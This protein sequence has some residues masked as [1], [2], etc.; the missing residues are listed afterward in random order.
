MLALRHREIEVC[1]VTSQSL[2]LSKDEMRYLLDPSDILGS[3]CG[4]ESFGALKRAEEKA[5]DGHFRTRDL[6]LSTWDRMPA[7]Q[8]GQPELVKSA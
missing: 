5:F 7:P 4:F 6:I 1:Q 3:D 2:G 8:T